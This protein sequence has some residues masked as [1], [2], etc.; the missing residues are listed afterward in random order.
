MTRRRRRKAGSKNHGYEE[1]KEA[2]GSAEVS[3]DVMTT[4]SPHLRHTNTTAAT[5]VVERSHY[6]SDDGD[7]GFDSDRSMP[8][9]RMAWDF[10]DDL[11][12]SETDNEDDGCSDKEKSRRH[13]DADDCSNE[14]GDSGSDDI[15]EHSE[16]EHEGED[17]VDERGHSIEGPD[18]DIVLIGDAG[19]ADTST[20]TPSACRDNAKSVLQQSPAND[21][22]FTRARMAV[23]KLRLI[24]EQKAIPQSL[25]VDRWCCASEDDEDDEPA[26]GATPLFASNKPGRAVIYN[27]AEDATP[28]K[29]LTK[30]PLVGGVVGNAIASDMG[31]YNKDGTTNMRE[32]YETTVLLDEI[33]VESPVVVGTRDNDCSSRTQLFPIDRSSG[34]QGE[35]SPAAL[36]IFDTTTDAEKNTIGF[37]CEESAV[38]L[39][40]HAAGAI[41]N[42]TEDESAI[43][44]LLTKKDKRQHHGK[45]QN[46]L[47]LV[48][49]TSPNNYYCDKSGYP[50]PRANAD[51]DIHVPDMEPMTMPMMTTDTKDFGRGDDRGT[52]MMTKPVTTMFY[53]NNSVD[54]IVNI[55]G[56]EGDS[57][58]MDDVMTDDELF[59]D[60][61][62]DEVTMG[63]DDDGRD[64]VKSADNECGLFYAA[65]RPLQTTLKSMMQVISSTVNHLKTWL[66][67]FLRK[68]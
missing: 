57:I 67:S 36:T 51:D 49:N 55:G 34:S 37:G 25:M 53:S 38:N 12:S 17:D 68:S 35:G 54:V 8:R 56:D 5:A 30:L 52:A 43:A 59:G 65:S 47:F 58:C 7:V 46:R 1:P 27:H 20:A 11:M 9:P 31:E 29:V 42:Q 10:G 15:S 44:A 19:A 40:L 23:Q 16:A 39:T 63:I 2:N 22:V 50:N 4:M 28:E 41:L 62:N 61:D 60:E 24:L 3:V 66:K 21:P 45:Q 33:S 6:C 14:V 48:G 18:I 13:S 26:D 32:H 64:C